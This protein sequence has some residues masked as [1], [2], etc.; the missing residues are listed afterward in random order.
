MGGETNDM[1]TTTPPADPGRPRLTRWLRELLRPPQ[2]LLSAR[3]HSRDFSGSR[4]EYIFLRQRL[5][6]WAF[7]ALALMWIPVD[8]LFL[9]PALFHEFLVMR[10]MFAGGF[11]L[12]ALWRGRAG[13][14]RLAQARVAGFVLIPGAFYIASLALLG[15]SVEHTGL[16]M[17]YRFL[18]FVMLATLAVFPLTVM[19]SALY[20]LGVGAMFLIGRAAGDLLLTPETLADAWLLTLLA[21]LSLWVE[22]AQI[23]MLLRLYREATRD[24]LT[25]LVN[26][27]V[28]IRW[29]DAEVDRAQQNGEPLSLLLFDL[30]LFK[31]INDVHGHLVGDRVLR[32]FAEMLQ[33]SCGPASA[34]AGR[35]GGEEFLLI[36]SGSNRDEARALAEQIRVACKE[37]TV[38]NM[39]GEPV[40]FTTSIGVAELAPQENAESFLARVDTGLYSAKESGRD[41]VAVA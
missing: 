29:L 18:P 11:V 34:L 17:G 19:E 35:Y 36:L 13:D 7:A 30:D 16:A 25:G 38:A 9:D 37:V 1:K 27:R 28:L 32:A 33:R 10:L 41:F 23:H 5:L 22:V 31:R 8:A 2:E 14:L 20:S 24:A 6:A 26:R 3:P 39:A 21:G 15:E 12:L 4:A 40:H